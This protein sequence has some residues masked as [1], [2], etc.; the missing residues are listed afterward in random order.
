[1]L[2]DLSQPYYGDMPHASSLPAPDIETVKDVDEDGINVQ[3]IRAP[4]H[5]GTHVD[6]PR[7]FISDGDTID[8]IPLERFAGEAVVFD[9]SRDE[10]TEITVADV[11]AAD[12]EVRPGDIV[13]LSTGWA[14]RY[15]TDAYEPHPW[16]APE[17]AD[18]LVDR[19]CKLVGLDVTTP[20]IPGSHRP[21]GWVEF[22]VHHRLLGNDVLV[23]EHLADL[24]PYVG[25]RLDVQGFPVKIRDGDG[26]PVRFVAERLD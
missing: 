14:D 16:L 8:D 15:G 10:A 3:Y 6:A 11:E 21:D 12:G 23:A 1:M 13:L 17:V 20:D 18:W 4:T 25:D 19:E 9:V 24:S 2:I 7:H 22:P 5:V 26:A